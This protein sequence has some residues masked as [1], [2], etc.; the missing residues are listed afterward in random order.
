VPEAS[1]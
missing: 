1:G